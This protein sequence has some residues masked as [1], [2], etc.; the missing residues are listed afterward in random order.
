MIL[1]LRNDFNGSSSG[2]FNRTWTQYQQGF[3]N[4]T[5]LYWI[6]LDRLHQLTQ[7]NCQVRFDLQFSD[8]T[9]HYAQYSNFSV[10]NASTKYRLSIGG[11]SGNAGESMADDNG[12]Q[13]S[14]YDSDHD[15]CMGINCASY[16]G[17]GFW[18][19]CCGDAYIMTSKFGLSWK[20]STVVVHLNV[21]E[22]SLLC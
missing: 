20:S 3:G 13:F 18:C 11:Y 6:G 4:P 15:G 16:Y 19:N 12:W 8:R 2:Y 1:I 21:V 14:T 17:G 5:A 22:V 7:G 9:W 10:G